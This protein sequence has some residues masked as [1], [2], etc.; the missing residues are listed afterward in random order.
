MHGSEESL[1]V[2]ARREGFKY[3]IVL[4]WS[5]AAG[6]RGVEGGELNICRCK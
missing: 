4:S 2:A 6:G 3:T 1:S 5:S